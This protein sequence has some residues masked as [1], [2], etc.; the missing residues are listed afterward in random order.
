MLDR[1]KQQTQKNPT[2]K[3]V[4]DKSR[5]KDII[6][7]N[8]SRATFQFNLSQ[9]KYEESPSEVIKKTRLEDCNIKAG[10]QVPPQ[11]TPFQSD[12]RVSFNTEVPLIVGKPFDSEQPIKS[13]RI[14]E[15]TSFKLNWLRLDF[16]V[17]QMQIFGKD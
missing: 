13:T 2:F 1:C 5:T 17:T 12:I 10:V 11:L 16:T 9:G 15:R 3:L 7:A 8:G 14:K 4:K 6:Y